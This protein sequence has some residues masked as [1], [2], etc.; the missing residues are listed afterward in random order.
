MTISDMI[1]DSDLRLNERLRERQLV[2]N[3]IRRLEA[4][5]CQLQ[6]YDC[7]EGCVRPPLP[8]AVI[9]VSMETHLAVERARRWFDLPEPPVTK[10]TEVP[11]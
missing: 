10:F 11:E 9:N 2:A 6:I 5:E 7:T 8:A 1:M 4:V 3:L